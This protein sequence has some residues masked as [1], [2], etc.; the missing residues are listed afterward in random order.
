MCDRHEAALSADRALRK[1]MEGNRRYASA[2]TAHPNQTPARRAAVVKG[3]HP[4]AVILGCSDSR[5]PPEI[6]FDQGLGD[7]FV[8]RLAGHILSEEARGSIE[9]AV[10]HLGTRLVVVLGHDGCGAVTAA[11]KGGGAAGRVGRVIQAIAPAVRKARNKPGDLLENA[12]RENVAMV[13]E[14]LKSSAPLLQAQVNNGGLKIIGAHYHLND[15]KVTVGCP[16]RT[17]TNSRQ[18]RPNTRR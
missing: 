5:V 9:Y 10:D 6:I 11:V 18:G 17:N 1:L 2:A 4:F 12:I 16:R 8:V 7:L 14:Q 13:V 3:Q 15:G